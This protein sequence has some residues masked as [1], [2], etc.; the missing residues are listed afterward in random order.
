MGEP[1]GNAPDETSVA[2]GQGM[3]NIPGVL[4]AANKAGVKLHFIEDEH[5]QSEKQIPPS[6]EYLAS[7]TL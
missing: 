2:L 7:L 6:L 4:R 1:S 3:V 5:P